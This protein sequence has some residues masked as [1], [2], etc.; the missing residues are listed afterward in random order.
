M[1]VTAASFAKEKEQRQEKEKKQEFQIEVMQ[2]QDEAS[3]RA[4]IMSELSWEANWPTYRSLLRRPLSRA[5]ISCA[6]VFLLAFSNFMSVSSSP[7]TPSIFFGVTIHIFRV[8]AI[9]VS[10][11]A[12]LAGYYRVRLFVWRRGKMHTSD[13]DALH[14]YYSRPGRVFF[15]L[16][17]TGRV[18]GT[19]GVDEGRDTHFTNLQRKYGIQDGGLPEL[20][21]LMVDKSVQRRGL[22]QRLLRHTLEWCQEQGHVNLCLSTGEMQI[23]AQLLYRKGGFR[24][25]DRSPLVTLLP[26]LAVHRIN[27]FVTFFKS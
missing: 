23:P 27:F 7:P 4:L 13:M 21:R 6:T 5:I 25:I 9:C 1:T 16:K 26:G 14:A 2:K 22:G 8:L 18:M 12:G 15:V 20:R 10:V 11:C 24:I 17:L 3:A 19:V